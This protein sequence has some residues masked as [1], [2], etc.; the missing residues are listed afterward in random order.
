L[1][2]PDADTVQVVQALLHQ[3]LVL[4][5]PDQH[6]SVDDH[7]QLG[8]ALGEVCANAFIPSVDADHPGVS[9]HRS[10]DG[11]V[12]DVWHSDGQN[13]PAPV[14]ITILKMVTAPSRGGDTMW[15][16]Q[17][18]VYE[19][20]SAPMRHL[21]DSLTALQRSGLNPSEQT[22]HSA[23][24]VHPETGRKL[25]YVSKHHTVRFLELT[26]GESRALLDFLA[27]FAVQ[28]EFV[29][30]YGWATGTVGI[31]DNVATQHYGVNDFA[32][33][34][35]FHRVMVGGPVLP[36]RVDR[37]PPADDGLART[38]VVKGGQTAVV[39]SMTT[40]LWSR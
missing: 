21:L 31:W 24:I 19:A 13:R 27:A 22:T 1:A 20:L 28:P 39:G 16:N 18:A 3:Y 32:E 38:M 10:D 25:L 29:C 35:V 2:R 17:Y 40:G 8:E 23:V 4:F 37:W 6:L 30:R 36:E 12:A 7:L 11:Y 26:T 15:A 9:L 33:P 34:R 5:F 14:A